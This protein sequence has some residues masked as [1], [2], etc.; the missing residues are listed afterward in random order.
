MF[1]MSGNFTCLCCFTNSFEMSYSLSPQ[2]TDNHCST[3]A[4]CLVSLSVTLTKYYEVI[5]TR[6]AMVRTAV[7]VTEPM[8]LVAVH[9]YEPCSGPVTC[10]NRMTPLSRTSVLSVILSLFAL[11]ARDMAFSR[12]CQHWHDNSIVTTTSF[13][14][15]IIIKGE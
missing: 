13:T 3:A 5:N 9:T 15:V 7:A 14:T 8:S 11:H 1:A 2:K 4:N 12:V 6:P 10:M